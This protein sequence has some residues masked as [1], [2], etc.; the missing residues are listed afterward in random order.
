M[1]YWPAA[2]AKQ[3]FGGILLSNLS[4]RRLGGVLRSFLRLSMTV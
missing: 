1:R 3:Q 4:R 2:L